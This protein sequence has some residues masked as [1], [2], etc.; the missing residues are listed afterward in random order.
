[1]NTALKSDGAELPDGWRMVRLDEIA[2]AFSNGSIS[3]RGNR[4]RTGWQDP[5]N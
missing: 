3:F 2:D 4:G 5:K 1:M